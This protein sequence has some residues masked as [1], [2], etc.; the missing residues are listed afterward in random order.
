M[1]QRLTVATRGF[2]YPDANEPAQRFNVEFNAHGV[3][4]LHTERRAGASSLIRLEPAE[5]GVIHPGVFEDRV[6]LRLTDVRR[7]F[8]ERLIAIEDRR[9]FDH[10]GIDVR[11]IAR[12]LFANIVAGKMKQGGSTITQQLVKNLYLSRERTLRRKFSEALMALSLERQFLKDEIIQ[13]YINEIYLGQDGN[14]AIHGF[15]LGAEFYFGKP[16]LELEV[17]EQALLIGLIKGPSAYDPRR[18]PEKALQRRNTVLAALF[19]AGLISEH[20]YALAEA[21]P[22]GLSSSPRRRNSAFGMFKDLV[23]QRLLANYDRED[24]QTRGLRIF[25]TL[26][27]FLQ[28][29]IAEA[30]SA[31]ISNLKDRNGAKASDLQLAAVWVEPLT[32]EVKA[33]IG[34]RGQGSNFNRAL[35][36]ERHIGSLIKPIIVA[37]AMSRS[38]EFHLGSLLEDQEISVTDERGQKWQ[39]QNY[40]R[41]T[42]GQVTIIDAL[43]NSYNLAMIDLG[44]KLGLSSVARR[45]QVMGLG[46]EHIPLYPSLLLGAIEMSPFE[47][48]QLYNTLANQGFYAPLKAIRSVVDAQG[49]SLTETQTKV[50]QA[51]SPAA[52][53][54][55]VYAMQA[56]VEQGTARSLV[57]LVPNGLPLA[58]KTGTTD[59]TRD[60]WFAGFGSNLLGV[61]WL[62][63][64]DASPT[65]LTGSSGALR[66]W[67]A[68]ALSAGVRPLELSE[69]TNI[70]HAWFDREN[71]LTY[72]RPCRPGM[73]ELPFVKNTAAVEI[74]CAD[75]RTFDPSPGETF[76]QGI[77]AWFEDN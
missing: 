6:V 17:S 34:G 43:I 54:L 50:T 2:Q 55:T 38:G 72:A 67:A 22:L 42:H 71:G 25:T 10:P 47:V 33:L 58:G 68:M 4:H 76:W 5:I 7:V 48:A 74:E 39:P 70:A 1:G 32:A 13:T 28:Q 23:H 24:L 29:Q 27:P 31:Y 66:A 57:G 19:R 77:K 69:P 61:V 37:E 65:G 26:D 11:G 75:S 3:V 12:A 9:F 35:Y 73:R 40:D 14:R 64:D 49:E 59:D 16:L 53:Y 52:V 30:R 20:E 63:N 44:F 18:Y 60:S 8:L 15:G 41:S 46:R 62:G 51:L 21:R 45:L 36:A 56:V